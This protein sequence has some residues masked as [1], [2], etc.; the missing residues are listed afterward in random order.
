MNC[1]FD[2]LAANEHRWRARGADVVAVVAAGGILGAEARYL[3]SRLWAEPPGRFPYTTFGVNLFGCFLIG[4]LLVIV[5]DMRTVTRLVRPFLA[6]GVLGGFTTFSTYVVDS[7]RLISAG[8][9][10]VALVNIV[11]TM[12]GALVAVSIGALGTRRIIALRHNRHAR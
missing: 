3:A 4:V 1:D 9:P 11:G 8:H 6:T 2:A 7:Q 5:S 10:G 12:A